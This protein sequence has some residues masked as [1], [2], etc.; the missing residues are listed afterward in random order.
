MSF[1]VRVLGVEIFT[2]RMERLARSLQ[3]WWLLPLLCFDEPLYE[4]FPPW[5]A[6][7]RPMVEMLSK[8]LHISYP[9]EAPNVLRFLRL[10]LY[11]EKETRT[12]GRFF[13]SYGE[14]LNVTWCGTLCESLSTN[15]FPPAQ[16]AELEPQ[17]DGLRDRHEPQGLHRLDLVHMRTSNVR[18]YKQQ[19][20]N[21]C[22]NESHNRMKRANV[23]FQSFTCYLP[24]LRLHKCTPFNCIHAFFSVLSHFE[25]TPSNRAQVCTSLTFQYFCYRCYQPKPHKRQTCIF[26]SL[27]VLVW[28][29]AETC[30]GH[31]NKKRFAIIMHDCIFL[32][33]CIL[34]N[35]CSGYIA[36]G[37]RF[38]IS[39]NSTHQT[40]DASASLRWCARMLYQCSRKSHCN[41]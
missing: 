19:G 39:W 22:V 9:V 17:K 8:K 30:F 20:F 41:A 33:Y 18:V 26:Y 28:P 4:A 5:C 1:R 36:N 7:F 10:M 31:C 27:P 13:S 32:Q 15:L 11:G 34:P 16:E 38:S 29:L 2:L 37:F 6:N 3:K 23:L 12:S 24:A 35:L 21:V 14:L 25:C 40:C